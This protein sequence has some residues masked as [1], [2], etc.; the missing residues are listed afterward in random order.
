LNGVRVLD[1]A[2][3]L[4]AEYG[5]RIL[6]ELGADVVKLEP[7]PE[8]GCLRRAARPG[9]RLEHLFPYANAGKRSICLDRENPRSRAVLRDLVSWADVLIESDVPESGVSSPPVWEEA[10][11]RN[12]GLIACT[13]SAFG[14]DASRK[15]RLGSA[16]T[17]DGIMQA[18]SGTAYVTGDPD[19]PPRLNATGYTH[20]TAGVNA[21][22]AITHA[23]LVRRASGSGQHID[24]AVL[25]TALAMDAEHA[26]LVA[27]EGG[28]Y[29]AARTGHVGDVDTLA[30]YRAKDGYVTI[31][32]WGEGPRSLWGRLAQ[33]IGRAD[34]LEDP[35][36]SDDQA[37]MANFGQLH[38]IVEE[39]VGS[40]AS[41][42]TAVESLMAAK[43][44]AG[45]V[46]LPWETVEHP[47][48]KSRGV[49]ELVDTP[50]GK[51]P[52]PLAA[53]FKVAGLEIH[54]GIPPRLG[55]HNGQVLREVLGYDDKEVSDLQGERAL[56]AAGS[57]S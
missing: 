47:Q 37:R 49:I 54:A 43:L 14:R 39:W 2:D 10:V 29:Q 51:V 21:C 33:T 24:L 26:S 7:A 19:G 22:I 28:R 45:Q 1:M 34:L 31:E 4:A 42:R 3:M 32:V 18:L 5:A 17:M 55:Q 15:M 27:A 52:L 50:S 20:T 35:R 38:P 30:L 41:A 56:C 16:E 40:F 44:V 12:P 9:R 11:T 46:L 25:D 57:P 8:G 23:L 13:V 53:P 6:A 36:F 48:V